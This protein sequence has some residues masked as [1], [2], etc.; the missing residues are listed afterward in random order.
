MKS[1]FMGACGVLVAV[2]AAAAETEVVDGVAWLYEPGADGV[3]LVRGDPAYAG[4]LVVP[5]TLGG[6]PVT[7]ID[8]FAFG[9]NPAV[10]SVELPAGV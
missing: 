3:T 6:R 4:D 9:F 2:L 8:T 7:S 5:A 1:V 10:T